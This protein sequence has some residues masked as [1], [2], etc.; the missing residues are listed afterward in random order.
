MVIDT[1]EL[2]NVTDKI[3]AAVDSSEI[4]TINET[5]ELEVR[6]SNLYISV[7]NREYFVTVKIYLGYEEDLH[8]SVSANM[9]L[10]LISQ[11]TTE[12]IEL[13][14][15]ENYLHIKGNGS[16]KLPLIFDGEKLLTLPKI[17]IMNPTCSMEID[18]SILQSIAKYNSREIAKSQGLVLKPVQKMYYVDS[19][20]AITY[21]SGACVNKFTLEKPVKM[22]LNGKVVKLFK[23][24]TGENIKFTLGY[25]ALSSDIIQTKVRFEDAAISLTAILQCDD[26]MLDSVPVTNIRGRAEGVYP[27]SITV[28]KDMFIQAINRLMIFG[29]KGVKGSK[30]IIAH[31]TFDKDGVVITDGRGENLENVSYTNSCESLGS[32]PYSA[33]LNLNDFKQTLSACEESHLTLNFGNH[34]AFVI[35]RTHIL[36]VVPECEAE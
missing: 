32:E 16:Y 23:L 36:N 12:D 2:K 9:F 14:C 7:T 33:Y 28:S 3:L 6:N 35:A 22:L 1:S 19:Q 15:N 5:L 29:N 10:N 31:F 25:D 11:I 20:G 17:E 21:T 34:Q 13:T 8:A 24:F 18:N 26:T 30:E 4:S 27:Y